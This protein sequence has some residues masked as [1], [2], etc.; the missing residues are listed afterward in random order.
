[1]NINELAEKMRKNEYEVI[2]CNTKEEANN[3]FKTFLSKKYIED[4]IIN[5]RINWPNK[6]NLLG[7]NL[8]SKILKQIDL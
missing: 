5:L 3:Y 6:M 4:N 2:V 8:I 1:M 7:K